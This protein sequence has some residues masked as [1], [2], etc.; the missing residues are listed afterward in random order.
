MPGSR[1]QRLALLNRFNFVT[2][3][4]FCRKMNICLKL[5]PIGFGLDLVWIFQLW[6][7]VE[8]PVSKKL[9]VTESILQFLHCWRTPTRC[10]VLPRGRVPRER[11]W[12]G[13]GNDC[14]V[15][16]FSHEMVEI[17]GMG[18]QIGDATLFNHAIRDFPKK[19][20]NDVFI[21]S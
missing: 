5:I 13:G 21:G 12:R 16:S 15:Q 20:S 7:S 9:E 14:G 18:G 10:R 19:R 3:D 1:T 17:S 8:R 2:K 6:K 4:R 11:L